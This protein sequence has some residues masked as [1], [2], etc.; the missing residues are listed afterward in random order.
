MFVCC[1]CVFYH[2]THHIYCSEIV[3]TVSTYCHLYIQYIPLYF[4]YKG[5]HLVLKSLLYCKD[6][7]L[8][9]ATFLL[10]KNHA[11]SLWH[12][13]S[14][15][16]AS[17]VIQLMGS[18]FLMVSCGPPWSLLC[19]TEWLFLIFNIVWCSIASHFFTVV[20]DTWRLLQSACFV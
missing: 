10:E 14:V 5:G 2:D 20:Y 17:S 15:L 7:T 18:F 1:V 11:V 4:W 8:P 9:E 19:N 16:Y 12:H 13:H 3:S 6:T